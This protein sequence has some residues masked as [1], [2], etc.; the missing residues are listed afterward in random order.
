[1][2]LKHPS[3]AVT[4]STLRSR[5]AALPVDDQV[6]RP[7][8]LT[9]VIAYEVTRARD[10]LSGRKREPYQCRHDVKGVWLWLGNP[11][12]GAVLSSDQLNPSKRADDL[13]HLG[14]TRYPAIRLESDIRKNDC[15]RCE[16]DDLHKRMLGASI[17]KCYLWVRG[18]GGVRAS[19]SRIHKVNGQSEPAP[20]PWI[21]NLARMLARRSPWTRR[22]RHRR[23]GRAAR[24]PLS[25]RRR[26]CASAGF[27]TA[28]SPRSPRIS[29]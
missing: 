4:G 16:I 28:A 15:M 27:A 13:R 20:I 18:I 3:G 29:T 25:S 12:D 2:V 21:P 24:S 17:L 22:A 6:L 8:N 1:M 5:L 11:H 7:D 10:V 23:G 26:P 9:L 14:A 19:P